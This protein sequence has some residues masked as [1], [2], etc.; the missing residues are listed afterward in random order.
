M[1]CQQQGEEGGIFKDEFWGDGLL[2]V[3]STRG[4]TGESFFFVEILKREIAKFS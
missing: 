2:L 3:D 4:P 1:L